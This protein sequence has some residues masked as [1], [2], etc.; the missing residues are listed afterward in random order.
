[1]YNNRVAKPLG[2][3]EIAKNATEEYGMCESLGFRFGR[4]SGGL[5]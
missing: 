2:N 4:H 1:M 3:G 5:Q